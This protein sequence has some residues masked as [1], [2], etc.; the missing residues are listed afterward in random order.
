MAGALF[1]FRHHAEDGSIYSSRYELLLDRSAGGGFM[2]VFGLYKPVHETG[3]RPN[4]GFI[5]QIVS[6]EW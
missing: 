3:T 5:F 2:P 1:L 6:D 4:L